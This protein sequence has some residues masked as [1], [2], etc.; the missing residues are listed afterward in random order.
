MTSEKWVDD[1]VYVVKSVDLPTDTDITDETDY[2]AFVYNRQ[3]NSARTSYYD[4]F[5]FTPGFS[6]WMLYSGFGWNR[7]NNFGWGG[8]GGYYNM[9]MYSMYGYS[10]FYDPFWGGY[11]SPYGYYGSPYYGYGGYYGSGYGFGGGVGG[12]STASSGL[13]FTGPR[14][15]TS[16]YGGVRSNSPMAYKSTTAPAP[17]SRAVVPS[18]PGTATT[19][20]GRTV[21]KPVTTYERVGRGTN[22]PPVRVAN[23]N[24]SG[25]S[26]SN[27][28][29]VSP[30]Q[31]SRSAGAAV[32]RPVATTSRGANNSGSYSGGASR[33]GQGTQTGGSVT[34]RQSSGSSGGGTVGGGS[35]SGG[36]S[37]GGGTKTVGRR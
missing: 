27:T 1:D 26:S 5:D 9:G 19:A 21:A 11:Y 10:P 7:F 30:H 28:G 23:N 31:A 35:R 15:G 37:S 24:A 12:G 2:N 22:A 33:S 18:R 36:G 32:P 17:G 34:P 4:R 6:T 16:G 20:A 8:H 14:G 3:Q 25:R 29:A 13:H